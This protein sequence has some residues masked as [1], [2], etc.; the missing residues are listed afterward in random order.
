M[1][2]SNK[3]TFWKGPGHYDVDS[4]AESYRR[5]EFPH[6][7]SIPDVDRRDAMKLMGASLALA[8][9]ATSGCRSLIMPQMK[10][11]GAV[12]SPENRTTGIEQHFATTYSLSGDA[13]GL[14]VTSYEGVR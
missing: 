11:V 5:D 8:G 1:S 9:L 7:E 10:I 4:E 2:D 3:Q 6:R 14:L 12:Q 13:I